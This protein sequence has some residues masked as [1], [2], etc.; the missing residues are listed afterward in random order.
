MSHIWH[1][2]NHM[3]KSLNV[4][5]RASEK[6]KEISSAYQILKDYLRAEERK[7]GEQDRRER[8]EQ[9]KKKQDEEWRRKKKRLQFPTNCPICKE[10]ITINS[11]LSQ[12]KTKIHF[13]VFCKFCKG[14]YLYFFKD[15]VPIF[16]SYSNE[17]HTESSKEYSSQKND[18][19]GES[20]I[21]TIGVIFSKLLA[22]LLIS[23]VVFII[24][25]I[26]FFIIQPNDHSDSSSTATVHKGNHLSQS[27]LSN[28]IHTLK[29]EVRLSRLSAEQGVADAQYKMGTF[30][31]MGKGVPQDYKEAVKWYRL[32]AEQGF[33]K[34]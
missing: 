28:E 5:N 25:S 30:Y 2:D 34:A 21:W 8:E 20:K 22:F 1:P 26:I 17:N 11:T 3:G 6:F 24:G 15:G 12:S 7:K 27:K 31:Y 29:E 10:S 14:T 9:T 4:Q 33:T 13:E 19:R 18:N 16:P 23:W 32:A